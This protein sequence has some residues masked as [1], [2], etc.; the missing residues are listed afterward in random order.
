MT[1]DLGTANEVLRS[2]IR[3]IDKRAEYTTT[4]IEGDRPGVAVT[5]SMRKRSTTVTIPAETLAA[6]GQNSI[7][8]NQLRT[9][10]KQALDKMQFVV[11]PVA[12]T[13]LLRAKTAPDG[14]FRP[15]SGGRGRR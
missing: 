3:S 13:K 8:R 10:L 2:V 14:F 9:T 6:A 15:P 5:L 1:L 4:V 7:R 12:S 11:M